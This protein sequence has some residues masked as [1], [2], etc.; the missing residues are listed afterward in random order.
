MRSLSSL[1]LRSNEW[2][3][4]WVVLCVGEIS[5][6]CVSSLL[7]QCRYFLLTSLVRFNALSR[8][9]EKALQNE[10]IPYRVLGGHKF[11]ERLE[12][13]VVFHVCPQLPIIAV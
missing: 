11:F 2:L 6:S 7:V 10:K 4:V 3:Q 5:L 12:V 9:V 8:N 13:G 1:L